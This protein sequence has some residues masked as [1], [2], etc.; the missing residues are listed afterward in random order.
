MN[1]WFG[2]LQY[3][4]MDC[5]NQRF[6]PLTEESIT[7]ETTPLTEESITNETTPIP[8]QPTKLPRLT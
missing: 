5:W 1:G 4:G 6:T 8:F 2:E 3:F 7:N